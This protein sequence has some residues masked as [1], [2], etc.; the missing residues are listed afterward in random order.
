MISDVLN[1]EKRGKK[2][3]Q[4]KKLSYLFGFVKNLLYLNGNDFPYNFSVL[5]VCKGLDIQHLASLLLKS[6]SV[7][8]GY[9]TVKHLLQGQIFSHF[10]IYICALTIILLRGLGSSSDSWA[11][12]HCLDANFLRSELAQA[13]EPSSLPTVR[14]RLHLLCK[15]R[16]IWSQGWDD[17]IVLCY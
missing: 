3:K 17:R 5:W 1:K 13:P 4:Q 9:A 12:C 10:Y 6:S 2:P 16:G 14:T 7:R 8:S 11:K 15:A